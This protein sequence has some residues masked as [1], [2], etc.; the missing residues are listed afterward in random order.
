MVETMYWTT[1][2]N[3]EDHAVR[4]LPFRRYLTEANE[5][6]AKDTTLKLAGH[7]KENSPT[8]LRCPAVSSLMANT[9]VIRSIGDTGVFIKDTEDGWEGQGYGSSAWTM[10]RGPALTNTLT[11]W[12]PD[13][14]LLLF[15]ENSLPIQF[16]AP[17]FN[18]TRH[19]QWGVVTPGQMD[20]SKWLRPLQFEFTLWPNVREMHLA[21]GEPMAYVQCFSDEKV[22]LQHFSLNDDLQT[23]ISELMDHTYSEPRKPLAHRYEFFESN[24]YRDR[25]LD[26]IRSTI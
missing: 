23:I 3:L 6:R 22:N 14:A 16:C 20:I 25:I 10:Q 2:T 7:E 9:F 26:A 4:Q 11:T 12:M 24:G 17:F 15:S 19:M 21:A 8:M 5:I 18:Q 1:V 13:E